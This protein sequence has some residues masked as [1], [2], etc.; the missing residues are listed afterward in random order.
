MWAIAT[1]YIELDSQDRDPK[2]R[3]ELLYI[4]EGNELRQT[5]PM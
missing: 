2:K 5:L 4:H 1:K 3:Y